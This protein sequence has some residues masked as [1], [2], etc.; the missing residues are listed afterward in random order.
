MQANHECE[1][2]RG[3]QSAL[4]AKANIVG[5]PIP[6]YAPFI[7]QRAKLQRCLKGVLPTSV[8]AVVNEH[9]A[10]Y[11][12]IE[13]N[14]GRV[15][16]KMRMI[17]M[18]RHDA[19]RLMDKDKLSARLT[20]PKSSKYDAAIKKLEKEMGS[21][22]T[23]RCGWNQR[24]SKFDESDRQQWAAWREGKAQRTTHFQQEMKRTSRELAEINARSWR[25]GKGYYHYEP[26]PEEMWGPARYATYLTWRNYAAAIRAQIADI[27][28]LKLEDEFAKAMRIAE[29]MSGS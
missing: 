15:R 9:G 21:A 14:A 1:A 6:G 18:S 3:L 5:I 4:K 25:P 20:R 11:L 26:K 2:S 13:G 22:P 10:R 12:L 23:I 7:F 19:L 8:I 27:R 24:V 28:A 16:T 29:A 17:S